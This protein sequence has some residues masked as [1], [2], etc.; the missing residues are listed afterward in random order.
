M[1]NYD[2]PNYLSVLALIPATDVLVDGNG[3]PFDLS[4]Y[5]GDVLIRV[6]IGGNTAGTSPTLALVIKESSD[7]SNWSNS[8]TT[9]TGSTTGNASAQTVSYDTRAHLRYVRI[10]KDIGGS[11]SPSFPVSVQGYAQRQYNAG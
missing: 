2:L 7:N 1:L 6:D 10:D 4:V 8:N 5:E 11:N 3:S 9:I